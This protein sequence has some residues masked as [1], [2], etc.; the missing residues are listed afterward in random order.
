MGTSAIGGEPVAARPACFVN[1]QYPDADFRG[2]LPFQIFK[3]H[4]ETCDACFGDDE[5]AP[6]D[7]VLIGRSQNSNRLHKPRDPDDVDAE[8]LIRLA[9]SAGVDV[10]EIDAESPDDVLARLVDLYSD[11]DRFVETIAAE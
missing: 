6:D 7:P 3:G 8:T 9:E 4:K 5:P 1:E 11:R 10:D 2:P